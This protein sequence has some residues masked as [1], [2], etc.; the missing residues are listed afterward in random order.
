[1]ADLPFDGMMWV[2]FLS[3]PPASMDAPTVAELTAGVDLTPHLLP[4]GLATPASTNRVDTSKLSSTFNTNVAGRR[5]FDGLMV[6]YV[7]GDDSGAQAVEDALVY[8]ATG[9]LAIR[10]DVA[11]TQAIAADDEVELYPVQCLQPNPDNPA[12]DGRQ[13]VEVQFSMTG[14][15][16]AYAD[17]ATVVAGA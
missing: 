9:V 7:R 13:A 16:K 12:P 17:T 11:Y 3:T 14:D 10:R 4:D 2:S 8:R 1:M 6:K 5:T 15:P